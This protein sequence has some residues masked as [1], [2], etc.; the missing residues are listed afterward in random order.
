MPALLDHAAMISDRRSIMPALALAAWGWNQ[1][2]RSTA[3][4]R[5]STA[6]SSTRAV[7]RNR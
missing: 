7:E 2:R 1:T 5:A 3:R 4:T 6:S